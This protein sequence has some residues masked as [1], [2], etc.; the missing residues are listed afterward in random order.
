MEKSPFEFRIQVL[1]QSGKESSFVKKFQESNF[2]E[3][4]RLE[5]VDLIVL[6][7]LLSFMIDS[8]KL[9]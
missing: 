9:K 7:G 4:P 2:I 1:S 8:N 6:M 3:R 5:T